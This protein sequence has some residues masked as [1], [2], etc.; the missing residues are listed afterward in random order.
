[1]NIICT[2]LFDRSLN[3]CRD[4]GYQIRDFGYQKKV[5]NLGYQIRD[6]EYQ[7]KRK[8]VSK[9][10]NWVSKLK[11]KQ[12]ACVIKGEQ[13]YCFISQLSSKK[14]KNHKTLKKV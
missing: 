3:R 12:V 10:R 6:N 5:S 8:R 1:M 9:T 2:N 4:F 14:H 7:K 13:N 11:I